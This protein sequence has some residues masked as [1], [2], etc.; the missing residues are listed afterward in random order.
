M[1]K[2]KAGEKEMRVHMRTVKKAR[3][4]LTQDAGKIEKK[5]GK[6]MTFA[7]S[8]DRKIMSDMKKAD[9]KR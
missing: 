9:K 2:N 4:E 6:K 8:Q 7:L 3:S 1:T 5:I